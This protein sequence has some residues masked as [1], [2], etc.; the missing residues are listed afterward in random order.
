MLVRPLLIAALFGLALPLCAGEAPAPAPTGEIEKVRGEFQF[1]EGPASDAQ[2]NLFF[3]DIP[4]N[5]IYKLSAAGEFSVFVEPSGHCN[6]LMI[7]SNGGFY[8]CQMDG[9]LL[10]VDPKT[11]KLTTLASEY[12][13]KRF[14][15]PN[16]LVVDASGGIYFTD[17][18]FRA[19]MPLPQEKEGVYYRAADGKVT[20]LLDGL[21][22]PNGVLLSTDEKTL[23]VIPTMQKEMMAYPVEGPGKLG[24]G[25]VFCSLVQREGTTGPGGGGDGLTIDTQGNLYITSGL[26]IQ[27]YS[28][29]G[30]HLKTIEFP[31][32]PANVT[33]GGPERK[34][35]FVTARTGLY[36]VEMNVQGHVF[37]GPKA[38]E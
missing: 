5:R 16:D 37:P 3:T 26:G 18:R 23:Y 31:E 1:T 27:I 17:P 28:P 11:G 22:A 14:N 38:S 29:A 36:S 12:N 32:Q 13:G 21:P 35:L 7:T 33:F 10:Q 19:P 15:A 8:A 20:R 34:T 25:K 9:A 30:K 6:G 4:A 2:G 24:E